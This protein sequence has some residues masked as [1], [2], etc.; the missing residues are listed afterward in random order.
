MAGLISSTVLHPL[1]VIKIGIII[2]PMQ[3]PH[4]EKVNV[5]K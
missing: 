4:I 2:N 5:A 3:I 1:E